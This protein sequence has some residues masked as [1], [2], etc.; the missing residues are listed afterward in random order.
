MNSMW[1][2]VLI[3]DAAALA[4]L[5]SCTPPDQLRSEDGATDENR[6]RISL[7]DLV[8][9][10]LLATAPKPT[11]ALELQEREEHRANIDRIKR[12]VQQL[13]DEGRCP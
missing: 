11:P 12:Q 9:E 6:S 1:S 10:A 2:R 4:L 5:I 13:R 8:E 3:P 7:C